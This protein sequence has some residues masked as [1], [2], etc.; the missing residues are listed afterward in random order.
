[1]KTIENI[2]SYN[3]TWYYTLQ[4]SKEKK[5]NIKNIL[6]NQKIDWFWIWDNYTNNSNIILYL[7]LD[8]KLKVE[9]IVK[10]LNDWWIKLKLIKE[11]QEKNENIEYFALS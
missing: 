4:I 7:E 6:N 1:M 10:L 5:N 9:S 3:V 2:D 11:I 8:T